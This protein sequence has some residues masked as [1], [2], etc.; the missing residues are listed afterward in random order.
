M[1]GI[2]GSITLGGVN[3]KLFES[4][5]MTLNH[6]GPDGCG[7]YHNGKVSLG[8]TRLSIV[9]LSNNAAQPMH[10]YASNKM[11]IESNVTGGG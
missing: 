7:V 9:D 6:R 2:L 3:E 8:H 4:A 1:C 5:L 11:V 10:F